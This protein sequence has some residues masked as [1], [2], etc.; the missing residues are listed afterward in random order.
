MPAL[1]WRDDGSKIKRT[2]ANRL[3][4]L[5]FLRELVSISKHGRTVGN[6]DLFWLITKSRCHTNVEPKK[7]DL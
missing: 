2:V 6:I 1:L 3:F 7:V 5:T 4:L